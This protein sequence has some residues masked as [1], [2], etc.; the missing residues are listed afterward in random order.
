MNRSAPS[1]C[2][3]GRRAAVATMVTLAVIGSAHTADIPFD[4]RR[5]GYADLGR[6]TKAIQD[7]DT[8]NPATLWVL[9][10]ETLWNRKAGAANRACAD[11]HGDATTSMKGI[12][13]RYPAFNPLVNAPIDLEQR[14]NLCRAEHQQT[15]PLLFESRDLLALTAYVGRQSRGMA[16]A[17]AIDER[18]KPF[19]EAGRTL[20]NQR[21]GQLNLSCSQC[22]DDNWGKRLAGSFLPQGHANGYPLYRL[23]WQS[24]GSL[25]RRLRNCMIGMRA[26]PYDYGAPENV[27]LELYLMSRARGLAVETPAVRP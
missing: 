21:F 13:A 16:I 15:T 6:D 23:E 22:H 11:C 2:M 18:L 17:E 9:D 19:I 8:V 12:A 24:L 1:L 4:Q 3:L 25:Q 5:S 10:G 20:F 27:A 14:I 26:E 7:D